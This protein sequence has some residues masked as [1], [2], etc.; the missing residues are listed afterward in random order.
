M[1]TIYPHKNN[2]TK[3]LTSRRCFKVYHQSGFTS[4]VVRS[5]KLTGVH[6]S[7]ELV[8]MVSYIGKSAVVIAICYM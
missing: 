2:T 5:H 4:D 3:K 7:F 6:A 1:V 8:T